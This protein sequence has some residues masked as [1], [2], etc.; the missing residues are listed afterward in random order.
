MNTT[1]KLTIVSQPLIIMIFKMVATYCNETRKTSDYITRLQETS[2]L[3]NFLTS[4]VDEN[5]EMLHLFTVTE[6]I[7]PLLKKLMTYTYHQPF[8]SSEHNQVLS[9]LD[10]LIEKEFG[11]VLLELTYS[12][13]EYLFNL[14]KEEIEHL[15]LKNLVEKLEKLSS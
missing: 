2:V 1:K 8:V 6:E 3:F 9:T 11:K 15:M 4:R 13:Q 14:C 12:E 10:E 5:K 7:V